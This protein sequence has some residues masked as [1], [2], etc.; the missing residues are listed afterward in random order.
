MSTGATMT[1]NKT[2]FSEKTDCM[3]D[4]PENELKK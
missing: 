1:K 2:E 3:V 4:G